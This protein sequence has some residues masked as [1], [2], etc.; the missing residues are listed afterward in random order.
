MRSTHLVIEL[1]GVGEEAM[2][3]DLS[4]AAC[5]CLKCASDTVS[6]EAESDGTTTFRTGSWRSTMIDLEDVVDVLEILDDASDASNRSPI[7]PPE[8]V[9]LP[10]GDRFPLPMLVEEMPAPMSCPMLSGEILAR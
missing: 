10:D 9:E 8:P 2:S 1:G 3:S 6:N 4:L 7:A 5:R